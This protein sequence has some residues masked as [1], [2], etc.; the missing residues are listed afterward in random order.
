ME[1]RFFLQKKNLPL[2]GFTTVSQRYF[3]NL[4]TFETKVDICAVLTLEFP[5]PDTGNNQGKSK[6]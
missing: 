1:K 2:F 6:P 3:R 5:K 4:T